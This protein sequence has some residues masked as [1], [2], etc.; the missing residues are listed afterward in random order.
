MMKEINHQ[1]NHLK[2]PEKSY[3]NKVIILLITLVF[4]LFIIFI[5]AIYLINKNII[6]QDNLGEKGKAIAVVLPPEPN[7]IYKRSGSI[8]NIQAN[9]I[10]VQSRVRTTSNNPATAYEMKTFTLSIDTNTIYTKRDFRNFNQTKIIPPSQPSNFG[11]LRRGETIHY[12]S[13]VNIKGLTS[14][15]VTNIELIIK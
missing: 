13:N 1:N 2:L 15:Y 8:T 3:F 9:S 11:E 7:I 5:L 14:F 6:T 12:K 4:I 10:T